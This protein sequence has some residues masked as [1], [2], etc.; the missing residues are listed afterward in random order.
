MKKISLV[1]SLALSYASI[2]FS[3]STTDADYTKKIEL[4]QA[5]IASIKSLPKEE[6]KPYFALLSD[7]ENRKNTLR[8][9]LKTPASKRD[10]VWEDSWN[11][12]YSKATIKLEN[13]KVK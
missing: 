8:A 11:Q 4:I 5:K 1:L 9:L 7:V 6:Q 12:N 2:V 13:I 10:K 3:Q